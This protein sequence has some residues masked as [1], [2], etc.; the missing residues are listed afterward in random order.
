M[1]LWTWVLPVLALGALLI[2]STA[3]VGPWLAM[4]C[5]GAL[6]GAVLVAVHHAEVSN[7]RGWRPVL[8]TGLIPILFR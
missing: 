5:G 3:G 8:S 4:L 1:P 7:Q 6:A 2:A